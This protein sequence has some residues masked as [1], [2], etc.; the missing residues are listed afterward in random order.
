M[1]FRSG[2]PN[3]SRRGEGDIRRRKRWSVI[4]CVM[5]V[6]HLGLGLFVFMG[7]RARRSGRIVMKPGEIRGKWPVAE[8]GERKH[9]RTLF[10][11][12]EGAWVE[13]ARDAMTGARRRGPCGAPPPPA[14]TR[15]V[16]HTW[17][18]PQASWV[19]WSGEV[20]VAAMC[21]LPGSIR[22]G[23]NTDCPSL[24]KP[25]QYLG[26]WEAPGP[27]GRWGGR[28]CCCC[29]GRA[30]RAPRGPSCTPGG[31]LLGWGPCWVKSGNVE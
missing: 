18:W 12:G 6:C 14:D 30:A 2:S 1:G 20:V 9:F 4:I 28:G 27:R 3:R 25:S 8:A 24:T 22:R 5:I 19:R 11:E 21:P 16:I 23:R 7:G 31:S 29:R 15:T 10:G 17:H 13:A 26:G